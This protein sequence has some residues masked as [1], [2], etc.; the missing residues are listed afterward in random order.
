MD[1]SKN[2][3]KSVVNCNILLS[4]GEAA[5]ETISTG[6][7]IS[8]QDVEE[9]PLCQQEQPLHRGRPQQKL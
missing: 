2:A 8:E 5:K 9:E 3:H 1:D 4:V 6:F 7:M